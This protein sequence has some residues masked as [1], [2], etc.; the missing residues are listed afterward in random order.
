MLLAEIVE[1]LRKKGIVSQAVIYAR[2][3]SEN[4]NESSIDAQLRAVNEFAKLNQIKIVGEYVDRAKSATNDQREAFQRLMA[5][6]AS[7]NF[8]FVIVHKLD[9][10]ARNVGDSAKY[11]DLLMSNGV[12]LIST[13]ENYDLD[14]PEG[15]FMGGIS[16]LMA[17]LYSR[18]LSREVKKGQ[19][20]N[21]LKAMHN[22]GKP[23]LGYDVDHNTGHL[24]VNETEAV[25]VRLI[26]ESVLNMETYD[27]IA[28]KLNAKGYR[29][30]RNQLFSRRSIYEILRNP[31]YTGLYF[32]RRIAPAP[33]G[34]KVSSH[35]YNSPED[36][37]TVEN[38]LPVIISQKQFD[39]V[40][41]IMD[42]RRQMHSG[43][44]V[45]LLAGKLHCAI[46]GA[47]YCGCTSVSK[48]R[49][50]YVSY[51]CN[52]PNRGSSMVCNNKGVNGKML[53]GKV[54]SVISQLVFDESTIPDI[55]GRYSN[56]LEERIKN[57]KSDITLL[58]K[59]KAGIDKKI[60]NILVAVENSG[61]S[62]I[63]L[64]RLEKLEAEATKI[65]AEIQT[66]EAKS[67]SKQI[68]EDMLFSLF[69]KAKAM[70]LNGTLEETRKLVEL[71][72]DRIDVDKELIKVYFNTNAF[73]VDDNSYELA[74]EFPREEVMVYHKTK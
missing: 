74:T 39:Q 28:E 13:I 62:Q 12:V 19:R 48:G 69:N 72:I 54:L 58:K 60:E 14:T 65:Q 51:R 64:Q 17:E 35:K 63:L 44:R 70:L 18:N 46:C 34:K 43:K 71:L 49:L 52:G 37:I 38:G 7:G 24:I 45:Y 47:P 36:M 57:R 27:T 29:T 66:I 41:A 42:G 67:E 3:S 40:Q 33:L 25:A 55:I 68:D 59:S 2:F 21:A 73:V 50:P 22:G 16:A 23:P 26:F 30:K 56:A 61:S 1:K 53:D 10:F 9:R 32:Y 8:H 6:S 20:E 31:K 5:D 11:R 15:F 4:Q